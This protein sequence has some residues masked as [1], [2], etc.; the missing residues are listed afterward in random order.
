MLQAGAA[1]DGAVTRVYAEGAV[2][3]FEFGGSTGTAAFTEA[4]V[5]AIAT[6]G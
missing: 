1:L 5:E 6:G 4:V 3:P 2:H